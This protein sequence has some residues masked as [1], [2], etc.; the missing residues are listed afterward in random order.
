MLGTLLTAV[1]ILLVK[2]YPFHFAA[3]A[4]PFIGLRYGGKLAVLG[5]VALFVPLGFVETQLTRRLFFAAGGLIGFLVVLDGVLLSMVGETA[6]YWMPAH[7]SS[8]VD[9][10]ANALGAAIGYKLSLLLLHHRQVP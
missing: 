5:E 10:I 3:G 6:Q 2:L 4:G 7:V 8:L 1:A 9:L